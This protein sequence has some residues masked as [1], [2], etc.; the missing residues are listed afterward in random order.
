[1]SDPQ[2][3]RLADRVIALSDFMPDSTR[4][5]N[6]LLTIPASTLEAKIEQL[7][8]ERDVRTPHI[9]LRRKR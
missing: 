1:M 9:P 8:K 4:Y 7:E 5:R 3:E 2:K 6:Y